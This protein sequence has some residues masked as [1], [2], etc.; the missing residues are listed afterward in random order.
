[1]NLFET[2]LGHDLALAALRWFGQ[3][4][5]VDWEQRR[6][7]IA[8]DVLAG[9]SADGNIDVEIAVKR[10]DKLIAELKKK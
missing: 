6:Y 9:M 10:A 8:K 2:N 1:M 4:N 3:G 5:K 7:E